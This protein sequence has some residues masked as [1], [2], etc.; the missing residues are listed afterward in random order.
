MRFYTI[1]L[2]GR[3]RLLANITFSSSFA[4]RLVPSGYATYGASASTRH[5]SLLARACVFFELLSTMGTTIRPQPPG[6]RACGRRM[7]PRRFSDGAVSRVLYAKLSLNFLINTRSSFSAFA[8]GLSYFGR[9]ASS[10]SGDVFACTTWNLGSSGTM[11][12]CRSPDPRSSLPW[13]S[14]HAASRCGNVSFPSF[15]CCCCSFFSAK[16]AMTLCCRILYCSASRATSQVFG[17]RRCIMYICVFVR[18]LRCAF[19]MLGLLCTVC[20]CSV[21]SYSQ[22]SFSISDSSAGISGRTAVIF[23]SSPSGVSAL[24]SMDSYLS[25][26]NRTPGATSP[27][28]SPA[29]ASSDVEGASAAGSAAASTAAS[30]PS[31]AESCTEDSDVDA[32]AAD[33]P[34]C[35][36]PSEEKA[37]RQRALCPANART[38][39]PP[40]VASRRIAAVAT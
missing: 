4:S 33:S 6:G 36:S 38:P 37:A 10:S 18:S 28:A 39:E 20:P 9:M 26:V 24:S 11:R 23:T 3:D 34:S 13:I 14:S 30:A 29:R 22:P 17:S 1:F 19:R 40:G 2:N 27:S 32:S 8:S 16:M 7:R 35:P 5:P 12:T 15:K 25:P 31:A 21:M